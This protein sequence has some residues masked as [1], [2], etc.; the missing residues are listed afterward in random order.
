ME[1]RAGGAGSGMNEREG[2]REMDGGIGEGV[3]I[4]GGRGRRFESSRLGPILAWQSTNPLPSSSS[5]PDHPCPGLVPHHRGDQLQ[6][7]EEDSGQVPAGDLW[8]PGQAGVQ[9]AR[10]RLQGSFLTRGRGSVWV[11]GVLYA[12]HS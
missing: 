4:D 9:A 6:G 2:G 7:A 5:P 3:K 10:L 11:E 1:E 12:V 8:Q